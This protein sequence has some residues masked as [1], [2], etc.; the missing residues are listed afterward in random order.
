LLLRHV[1]VISKY[2]ILQSQRLKG[3]TVTEALRY[4][5]GHCGDFAKQ[6][7]AKGAII[8]RMHA[9][10][11]R[12]LSLEQTKNILQRGYTQREDLVRHIAIISPWLKEVFFFFFS[13]CKSKRSSYNSSTCVYRVS[14]LSSSLLPLPAAASSSGSGSIV[15]RQSLI[16]PSSPA[17][18]S[19]VGSFGCHLTQFISVACASLCCTDRRKLGFCWASMS[20]LLLACSS[21]MQ[22]LLSPDPVQHEAIIQI[23]AQSIFIYTFRMSSQYRWEVKWPGKSPEGAGP[24]T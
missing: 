12:Q 24:L 16:L 4:A 21:N 23:S 11:D 17:E 1:C 5:R 7:D 14:S 2:A 18:A 13:T 3:G 15:Y 9:P 19:N 8:R 6:H 20:A 22:M 10:F